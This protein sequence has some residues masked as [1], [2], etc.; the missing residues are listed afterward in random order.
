MPYMIVGALASAAHGTP[1]STMGIDL[2]IDPSEDSFERLLATID[3]RDLY[4]D[5]DAARDA[6]IARTQIDLVDT[7]NAATIALILRKNRPFSREDLGRRMP[8]VINDLVTTFAS[9]EDTV[10]AALEC[11]S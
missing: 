7:R 6:Y 2:V 11:A 4:F 3:R 1:R 5:L 8:V 9:P 10:I